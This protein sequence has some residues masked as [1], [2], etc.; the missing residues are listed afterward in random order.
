MV[1]GV[2]ENYLPIVGYELM[3]GRNF[4]PYQIEKN[5][6]FCII[7]QEVYQQLFTGLSP[8]G[9][10]LSFKIILE[11]YTTKIHYTT[12]AM[13]EPIYLEDTIV[14]VATNLCKSKRFVRA[15]S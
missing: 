5:K 2:N 10:F 14:H 9:N 3:Q 15:G 4:S 11:N 6:P 7:G 8:I 13:L 12:H 1:L